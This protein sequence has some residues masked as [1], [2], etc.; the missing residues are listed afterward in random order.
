MRVPLIP[1]SAI[2]RK[3]H[4]SIMHFVLHYRFTPPL[5]ESSPMVSMWQDEN[6]LHSI[7]KAAYDP[8]MPSDS[9]EPPRPSNADQ[10]Q[11]TCSRQ[12]WHRWGYTSDNLD[13]IQT[14]EDFQRT[15]V[16][17]SA[18]LAL[19][20]PKDLLVDL[21]SLWDSTTKLGFPLPLRPEI[22]ASYLFW[23]E[24]WF[25]YKAGR[26]FCM[27]SLPVAQ[28]TFVL[29]DDKYKCLQGSS[30]SAKYVRI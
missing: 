30:K 8:A 25:E 17:N 26:Q 15:M 5:L 19:V 14:I 6:F 23:M 7:A 29:H 1:D 3:R 22:L 28:T 18:A 2:D 27:P 11:T 4:R 9:E 21:A 13:L 24:R 16:D 10:D 20:L 12:Y